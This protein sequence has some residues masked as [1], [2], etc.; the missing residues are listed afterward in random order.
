MKPLL[1][2]PIVE[3]TAA[4]LSACIIAGCTTADSPCEKTT[5]NSGITF[6]LSETKSDDPEGV[7]TTL[8]IDNFKV[9]A[10]TRIDYG[11]VALLDNVIVKRTGLNTWT[12]SPKVEWPDNPVNFYM[13]SP[14]DTYW[15]VQIW[16]NSAQLWSYENDGKTDLLAAADYDAV[17]RPGP[18]KVNFRHTLARVTA[19]MRNAIPENF[20]IR[21]KR[22]Y[23]TGIAIRGHYSW[24]TES[25]NIQNELNVGTAAV[26]GK[27][28][29]AGL[30]F[31]TN[32]YNIYEATDKENGVELQQSQNFI[33]V[34]NTGIQFM[35]PGELYPPKFEG[36]RW[37][38]A[39]L[40]V[41]YKIIDKNTGNTLWPSEST[42][43]EYNAEFDYGWAVAPYHLSE[44]TPGKE[45]LPGL[46]Y[47][48]RITLQLP[49]ALQSLETL[50]SASR[51]ADK[52]TSKIETIVTEQ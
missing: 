44:S 49:D 30:A 36:M 17:S 7:E 22:V 18:V 42:P 26:S 1:S 3:L 47:K 50:S 45:W 46:D 4:M 35:V 31:D 21:I 20:S 27:W 5:D 9:T 14:S 16:G 39:N 2:S 43:Q 13:V 15:D 38:G 29:E 6:R 23:L 11:M 40:M 34:S 19:T 41:I 52:A 37:R 48:Y 33:P 12:Y 51:S 28:S 10:V 24:P 32:V 8:T 25:T